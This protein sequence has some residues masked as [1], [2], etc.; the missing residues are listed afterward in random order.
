MYTES[1]ISKDLKYLSNKY[2]L[3]VNY[4]KNNRTIL[5]ENNLERWIIKISS[6]SFSLLH[7]NKQTLNSGKLRD[8]HFQKKRLRSKESLFNIFSYIVQ[9]NKQKIYGKSKME[10]LFEQIS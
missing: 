1:K 3:H 8:Y 4:F 7:S 9:H 5:I 2:N 6:S 10:R